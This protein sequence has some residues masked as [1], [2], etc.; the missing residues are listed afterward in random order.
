MGVSF[1]PAIMFFPATKDAKM[2]QHTINLFSF[3]DLSESAKKR[4]VQWAI[5]KDLFSDSCEF[6]FTDYLDN[7]RYYLEFIADIDNINYSIGFCKSDYFKIDFRSICWKKGVKEKTKDA[8]QCVKDFFNSVQQNFKR[9][10]YQYEYTPKNYDEFTHTK[11]G[12]GHYFPIVENWFIQ[13][14]KTLEKAVYYEL[15][16]IILDCQSE[17]NIAFLLSDDPDRLFT[18]EGEFFGW[19]WDVTP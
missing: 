10:L 12:T 15:R 8:P 1:L 19:Q 4:A 5:E 11:N 9:L 3:S 13:D 17:G 16:D 2:L 14:I 7:V 6:A 18:K